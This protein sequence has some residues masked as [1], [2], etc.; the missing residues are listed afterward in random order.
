M[1]K[2]LWKLYKNIFC[3]SLEFIILI[4]RLLP[5]FLAHL[6]YHPQNHCPGLFSLSYSQLIVLNQI[7]PFIKSYFYQVLPEI[8]TKFSSTGFASH[9][10][11]FSFL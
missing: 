9:T 3:W 7:Q 6:F 11:L 4:L 1:L 10:T 8:S 5:W 2:R